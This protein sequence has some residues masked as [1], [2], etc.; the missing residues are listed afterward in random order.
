MYRQSF[1]NPILERLKKHF[2]GRIETALVQSMDTRKFNKDELTIFTHFLTG[3]ILAVIRWWQENKQPHTVEEM[4]VIIQ[5]IVNPSIKN[6]R[7][8]FTSE[9]QI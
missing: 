6:L 3:G 7:G 4:D 9:Q 5:T 1:I 8:E 2:Y